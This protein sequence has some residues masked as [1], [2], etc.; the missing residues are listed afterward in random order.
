[1]NTGFDV[2]VESRILCGVSAGGQT[3]ALVRMQ[4]LPE[5]GKFFVRIEFP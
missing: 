4:A 1:M 3:C 5:I 2:V